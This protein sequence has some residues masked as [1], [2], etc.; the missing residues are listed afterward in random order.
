M[1]IHPHL[2]TN[3]ILSYID[4]INLDSKNSKKGEKTQD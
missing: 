2:I 4:K 3:K 1:T